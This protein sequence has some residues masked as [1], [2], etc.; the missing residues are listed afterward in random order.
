VATVDGSWD[1]AFQ[2]GRGAPPRITLDHLI[3]WPHSTDQ[4]AKYFSGTA[5]YT[6]TLDARTDWF[7]PG[8]HLWIDLGDVKN[9]AEVSVNGKPLGIVWKRPFRV[10]A[11][12]AIKVGKNQVEIKVTNGWANRIIGDRQ[13]NAANTYTFTS[14]KFYKADSALWPSGL[15]GPVQILR[16]TT[17][18][19][20]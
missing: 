7:S 16:T 4:G 6:K 9:M 8:A 18:S 5:T 20:Q 19:D 17:R 14:P 12:S 1:I 2:P 11:T 15:L 10:D 13:P 3:F